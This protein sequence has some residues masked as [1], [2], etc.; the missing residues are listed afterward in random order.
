MHRAKVWLARADVTLFPLRKTEKF[1]IYREHLSLI[2][3]GNLRMDGNELIVIE[4]L[5]NILTTH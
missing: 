1:H 5:L 4:T 2:N 3:I